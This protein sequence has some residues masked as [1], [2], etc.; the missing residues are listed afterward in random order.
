M[1]GHSTDDSTP[2]VKDQAFLQIAKLGVEL[3]TDRSVLVLDRAGCELNNAL[4]MNLSVVLACFEAFHL[5]L[6]G[7]FPPKRPH[8]ATA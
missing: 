6:K 7:A 1:R 4:I 3:A 5:L 8:S 2:L